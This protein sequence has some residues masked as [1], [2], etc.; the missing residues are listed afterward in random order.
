MLNKDMY[1]LTLS[2]KVLDKPEENTC[3]LLHAYSYNRDISKDS[4]F[5]WQTT[6]IHGIMCTKGICGWM[7][8]DTLPISWSTLDIFIDTQSLIF[9]QHFNW[10]SVEYQPIFKDVTPSSIDLY[11]S[12]DNLPTI[13]QLSIHCWWRY[14]SS[15]DQNVD[16]YITMHHPDCFFLTHQND[17]STI[18]NLTQ[19][20]NHCV[21]TLSAL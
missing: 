19:H 11:E 21:L 17:N 12:V 3:L 6:V 7:S 20:T 13:N 18:S 5:K 16:R 14:Q 15:V 4:L 9:N 2:P 10:Q 1:Y 8:T